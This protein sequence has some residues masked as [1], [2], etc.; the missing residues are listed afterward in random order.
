MQQRG[1]RPSWQQRLEQRRAAV[2]ETIQTRVNET[3]REHASEIRQKVEEISSTPS[4]SQAHQTAYEKEKTTPHTDRA[5]DATAI[6]GAPDPEFK[7]PKDKKDKEKETETVDKKTDQE[8]IADKLKCESDKQSIL[9]I[10]KSLLD[11]GKRTDN[12]IETMIDN[13]TK[14]QFRKDFGEKHAHPLPKHRGYP[15]GVKIN[16]YNIDMYI[17]KYPGTNIDRWVK[18]VFHVVVDGA[19]NAKDFW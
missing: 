8:T 11:R 10:L 13:D 14:I 17:R 5:K 7:P 15:D 4:T 3:V 9:E 2:D 16:H 18:K 6:G 19:G 12:R 1:I